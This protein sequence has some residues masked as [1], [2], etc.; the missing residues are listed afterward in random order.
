MSA[1][2]FYQK[3]FRDIFNDRLLSFVNDSTKISAAYD[4]DS[5]F[6]DRDSC[7]MIDSPAV[8]KFADVFV[9][10]PIEG[11]EGLTVLVHFVKTV[12]GYKF[13]G[14]STIP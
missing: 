6:P 3:Y 5:M 7:L 9:G 2:E 11:E 8:N 1:K 4:N 13:Y 12:S 10:I 14:V